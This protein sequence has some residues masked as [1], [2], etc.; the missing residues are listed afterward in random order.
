MNTKLT[1]SLNKNVINK[2]KVYAK[3]RNKSLS[4]IIENY[5][6]SLSTTEDKNVKEEKLPVTGS[7]SGILKG[8]PEINLRNELASFLEKKYK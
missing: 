1:L 8:K 6:K 7:L 3:K 4:Q 5:L 2:A